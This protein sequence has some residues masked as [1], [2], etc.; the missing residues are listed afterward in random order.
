ME[1]ILCWTGSYVDVDYLLIDYG[2]LPD[3]SIGVQRLQCL[4]SIPVQVCKY[5][6]LSIAAVSRRWMRKFYNFFSD[7]NKKHCDRILC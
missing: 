5:Q 2:L 3:L 1:N 7:V 4:C 6:P